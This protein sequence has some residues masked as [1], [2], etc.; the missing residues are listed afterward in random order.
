MCDGEEE[1]AQLKALC[2][3]PRGHPLH[4][5]LQQQPIVGG[6]K[7]VWQLSQELL[8]D[9]GHVMWVAV[10]REGGGGAVQQA[11]KWCHMMS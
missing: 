10:G 1:A 5:P 2:L 9:A 4:T 3:L 7:G 8:Q 11:L 6:E